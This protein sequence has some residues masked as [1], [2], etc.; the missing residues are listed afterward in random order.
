MKIAV[1]SKLITI[2][3]D[4]D[5]SF[6][7]NQLTI[8]VEY[9]KLL[10]QQELVRKQQEF[11]KEMERLDH[12]FQLEKLRL[13]NE[14]LKRLTSTSEA[15]PQAKRVSIEKRHWVSA[16]MPSKINQLM[17]R[18]AEEKFDDYDYIKGLL[19]K[20]FKL[21]AEI[22]RQKFVKHQRNPAQS[23]HDFVFEIT[24]YF[25]EWPGGDL[26]DKLDEYESVKINVKGAHSN[27]TRYRLTKN[28][29]ASDNKGASLQPKDASFFRKIKLPIESNT[30]TSR[31]FKPKC[32]I[33]ENVGHLAQRCPKNTK[34]TSPRNA[35][36]PISIPINTRNGIDDLQLVD[37]KCGQTSIKA[38]IDTGA[39]ILVLRKDLIGK[40]C[41]E[42]EG[43]I[44]IILAFHEKEIAVLK[45][46]NFK[47]DNGKHGSVP[48]I[49]TVSKKLINDMLINAT[50]YEIL[51]ENVQ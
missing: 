30:G 11:E 49:C 33:C 41:G 5:K 46:F 29:F 18:K 8:I 6:S 31:G 44:R 10:E 26:A 15:K 42:G 21:S 24:G 1:L 12:E 19:L 25:E 47:I 22:F 37:I 36:I 34:K 16:L 43:T 48:I 51:L 40:G 50:A 17:T 27:G 2:H 28:K 3:P 13:E 45:I 23:W 39:Q 7:R 14:R 32:F 35:R 4:Y 20:C 38:L 9:I